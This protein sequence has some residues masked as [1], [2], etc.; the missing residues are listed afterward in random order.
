MAEDHEFFFGQ[1]ELLLQAF[2]FLVKPW[3]EV[4]VG[5]HASLR[6]IDSIQESLVQQVLLTLAHRQELL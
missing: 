1:F 6:Q 3:L 4:P 5:V 2:N